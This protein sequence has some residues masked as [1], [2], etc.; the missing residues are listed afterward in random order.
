[1]EWQTWV[2][3]IVGSLFVFAFGGGALAIGRSAVS[4]IIGIKSEIAALRQE[5]RSFI[6]SAEQR[7]ERLEND[8]DDLKSESRYHR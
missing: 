4:A 2:L 5:V 7:L 1:M 6:H 8:V 3:G